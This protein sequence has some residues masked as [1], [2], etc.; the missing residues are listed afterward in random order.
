MPAE[1]KRPQHFS[2]SGGNDDE[3]EPTRELRRDCILLVREPR[4]DAVNNPRRGHRAHDRDRPQPQEK[5]VGDV[6][7][8]TPDFVLVLARFQ[9]S[10][11]RH[12]R[13]LACCREQVGDDVRDRVS[14][15]KRVGA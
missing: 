4:S 11:E 9:R 2:D 8:T 14:D 12:Q 15:V 7:E 3:E 5:I 13:E 10:E 1:K 6:T